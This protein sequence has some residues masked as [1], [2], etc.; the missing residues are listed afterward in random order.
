MHVHRPSLPHKPAHGGCLDTDLPARRPSV[1]ASVF[2]GRRGT[3]QEQPAPPDPRLLETAPGAPL[4]SRFESHNNDVVHKDLPPAQIWPT[5]GRN[6]KPRHSSY[7]VF[8]SLWE[9]K[10]TKT[11]PSPSVCLSPPCHVTL[12]QLDDS[13]TPFT[14]GRAGMRAWEVVQTRL[15]PMPASSRA[16]TL[17]GQAGPPSSQLTG[18]RE[19]RLSGACNSVW[20][21]L[22]QRQKASDASS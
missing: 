22:E 7:P 9:H 2:P 12:Q 5:H 11:Y 10:T 14:D 4:G 18:S 6:T 20:H 17:S 21:R 3:H 16:H 15:A 13:V 19:L 1:T 8:P